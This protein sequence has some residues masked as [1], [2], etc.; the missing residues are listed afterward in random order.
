MEMAMED[1]LAARDSCSTMAFGTRAQ[2]QRPRTSKS[3][4]IPGSLR[5]CPLRE[6]LELT[7]DCLEKAVTAGQSSAF[8]L[9]FFD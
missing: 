8:V 2:S 7:L 6:A 3:C 1:S 9:A 4:W 5:I